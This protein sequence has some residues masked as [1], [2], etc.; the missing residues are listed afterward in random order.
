MPHAWIDLLREGAL[1]VLQGL[2]VL[3]LCAAVFGALAVA[4]KG[5]RAFAELKTL[6]SELRITVAIALFNRLTLGLVIS[7][8]VAFVARRLGA[9]VLPLEAIGRVTGLGQWSTLLLALFIGDFIG[10]WRHRLQHTPWLWPAHAVH[11]GDPRL[12]WFSQERMHPIDSLGNA[13]DT[14]ILALL[15]FP[16][17]ALAGNT[18]VR[19]YWGY[20]IHCDLPWT[21]GKAG[22]VMGS[23]AMH[24]WHHARDVQGSGH[25]FATMFSVFDRLFGTYHTPGPC[26]VPLGVREPLG[27]SGGAQLLHPFRVWG[28]S[29]S[30]RPE[31]KPAADLTTG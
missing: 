4:T 7:G 9:H 12:C 24:R 27:R 21:L 26:D 25:N 31:P 17:W 10:Y 13:C 19:H 29:L 6:G 16:F 2:A 1:G 15:G 11:H 14:L 22:L 28:R 20:F 18:T 30:A 3:A 8:A 23:P 5:R